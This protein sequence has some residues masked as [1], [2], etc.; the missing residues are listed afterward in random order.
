MKSLLRMIASGLL[1]VLLGTGLGGA[2]AAQS[3]N[4]ASGDS[5]V[6]IF[7]DNGIEWRQEQL[8]FVARGNAKAV[9]GQVTVLADELRAYYRKREDESTEIWRLDA[10]GSVRIKSPEGT[11]YGGQAVYDV[12]NAVL[13]MTG[14][15]LRLVAGQDKLTASD[16]L[17]YWERKQ[18]AV[19]RGDA[20]AVR[21]GKRL[22][23]DVLAAYMRK[24]KTGA[25]A[26]YRVDAFDRVKIVTEK[27]TATSNRGVYNVESGIATLTGSVRI[28]R[29][30]NVLSGCSAEVN[31]NTG[32]SRLHACASGGT[33][34]KGV[35]RPAAKKR[36]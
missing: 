23:A 27:D 14:K 18:M 34:V 20:F 17:E 22:R 24:N 13:T 29:D 4:F 9:R 32:I 16:Q 3:L 8:V 12:D 10:I 30:K 25:T 26:I 7:A 5:P 6:E 15:G 19:A 1:A 36:Q 28:I 11:A 21:A 35:I 31:L 33:R 2:V